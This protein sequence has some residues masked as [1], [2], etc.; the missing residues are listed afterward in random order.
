MSAT[1]TPLPQSLQPSAGPAPCTAIHVF[2][3]LL[4]AII[5][6]VC[7][8]Y[9]A[10]LDQRAALFQI[11]ITIIL[12]TASDLSSCMFRCRPAERRSLYMRLSLFQ[13][14]L[15]KACN[16]VTGPPTTRQSCQACHDVIR[17]PLF[18]TNE[19]TCWTD[20]LSAS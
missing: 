5:Q 7:P 2:V 20:S 3:H 10:M 4:Q 16:G 19:T 17:S 18:H 12:Q 14:V 11:A 13:S 1:S 9:V 8:L 15:A 6:A